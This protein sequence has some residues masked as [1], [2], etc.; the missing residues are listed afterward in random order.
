MLALTGGDIALIILAAFWGV[1][2]IFLGVVLWVT[3]TVLQSTKT[4]VDGIRDET[5][6]LLGEV[7]ITVTSVNKELDRVDTIME[8]AGR[9]AGSA[10]RITAVV[11]Q[12]VN[13]P[14]IKV[15]AF[16]AGAGRAIRRLR[17]EK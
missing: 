16:A 13:N 10:Q 7:K 2:V 6:P 17:G 9:I 1:L 8:S 3:S 4:L 5:V 11:E 15:A 14:L 12:T